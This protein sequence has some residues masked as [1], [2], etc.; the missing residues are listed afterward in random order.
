MNA[1]P[2]NR[3]QNDHRNKHRAGGQNGA[4]EGLIEAVVNHA[5]RQFFTLAANF[6]DAVKNDN[7]IVDGKANECQKCCH[8][9]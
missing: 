7:R 8:N 2:A 4:A 6:A 9:W 5:G 3:V 1:W